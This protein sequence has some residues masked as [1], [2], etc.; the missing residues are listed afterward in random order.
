MN[1]VDE[2]TEVG[3]GG[4]HAIPKTWAVISDDEILLEEETEAELREKMRYTDLPADHEVCALPKP[5][6]SVFL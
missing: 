4:L 2:R 1:D 3:R 5:Y 6:T